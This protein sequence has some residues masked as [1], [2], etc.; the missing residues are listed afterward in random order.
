MAIDT[1]LAEKG[2]RIWKNLNLKAGTLYWG[3]RAREQKK[4]Q[5]DLINATIGSAKIKGKLMVLP[6]LVE[7]VNSL[8][9]DQ[10]Y[11]Y[12]NVRGIQGFGEAWKKDTISTYRDPDLVEKAR[13]LTSVPVPVAGGLTGALFTAGFTFFSPGDS[14]I[15]APRERWGNIDN[16]L[17]K[18]LN[19][20]LESFKQFD[21][22]GKLNTEGLKS[23]LQSLRDSSKPVSKIGI[24]LNFPNNPTGYMPSQSEVKDFVKLVK[25]IDQPTIILFDDA[26]E[27]FNYNIEGT[28]RNEQPVP[29]SIF[30]YFIDVNEN[31]LPV[32]VD[33][34]S[35]RFFCYGSRLGCISLGYNSSSSNDFDYKEFFAK[36]VRSFT[37]SAPHGLQEAFVKIFGSHEK[38]ESIRREK[39]EN[40]NILE[41]RFK[42]MKA[43]MSR[44]ANHDVL[45]P[46]DYNSG[47]FG[48]FE[49]LEGYSARDVAEQLLSKGLGTVA[50]ERV[51]GVRVA[52]CSVDVDQIS[53]M[54]DIL[55]SVSF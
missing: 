16:V 37:S 55:E 17:S 40:I 2:K 7:A 19:L 4:T 52:F 27:T 43:G 25:D 22:S 30:P 12:A 8:S 18:H 41:K 47:F 5:Q 45:K 6:T 46:V 26:Y 15:L 32:K 50:F 28:D 33:G 14:V 21:D 36:M 29:H 1:F 44:F 35:K 54:L 23:Q 20:K 9:P 31:V 24:Y 38:T 49:V 10:V 51:N 13:E 11:S 39:M 48:Y 42:V 53:S 3:L 34:T